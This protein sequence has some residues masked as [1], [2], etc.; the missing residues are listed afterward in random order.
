MQIKTNNFLINLNDDE[1]FLTEEVIE[2]I[3]RL[4]AK[5][6]D[7]QQILSQHTFD[8]IELEI[9][10]INLEDM[11]EVN[12]THRS[13]DYA[14]DVLSFPSQEMIRSDLF[15]VINGSLHLGDLLICHQICAKQAQEHKITY[16]DEFIH[17]LVHGLLHL[18]GYDHE[19]NE[20][21]DILM[22]GLEDKLINLL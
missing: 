13:K 19:I 17:L 9:S 16:K 3:K 15:E 12:K 8:F 7:S 1:N 22:R 21:E 14:T 4:F 10:A 2:I 11:Q 20:D 6:D 18:Y 5:L